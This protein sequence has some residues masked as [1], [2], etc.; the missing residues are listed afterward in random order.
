MTVG[1]RDDLTYS[2]LLITPALLYSSM[3]ANALYT[4]IGYFVAVFV[5][6]LVPGLIL[7]APS[8][9]LTGTTAAVVATLL[10]YMKIMSRFG[11]TEGMFVL[12][13]VFSVPGMLVGAGVSAWLLRYRVK[14]SLQWIVSGIG[15]LGTALGFM[16]AQMM[17]CNT[18][19]YCGALSLGGNAGTELAL[20]ADRDHSGVISTAS[21]S[22]MNSSFLSMVSKAPRTFS[23]TSAAPRCSTQFDSSMMAASRAS[24]FSLILNSREGSRSELG[25]ANPRF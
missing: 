25:I 7:R 5:A 6:S 17:V 8:L 9:F 18:L 23:A 13:H 21:V 22:L 3:G 12:G 4:G 15:F 2:I 14:A 10:I 16:V 11:H 1:R 19:M 20:L 24:W